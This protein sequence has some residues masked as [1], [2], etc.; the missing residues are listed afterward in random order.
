MRTHQLVAL[1]ALSADI[2]LRIVP[3]LSQTRPGHPQWPASPSVAARAAD[4]TP[5]A[6]PAGDTM[7]RLVTP[8]AT[9]RIVS[10]QPGDQVSISDYAPPGSAVGDGRIL[11]VIQPQA[12]GDGHVT[13]GATGRAVA[14]E[15]VTSPSLPPDTTIERVGHDRAVRVSQAISD[16]VLKATA[17]DRRVPTPSMPNML[18]FS[19]RLGLP[20]G[21]AVVGPGVSTGTTVAGVSYP[22]AGGTVVFLDLPVAADLPAGRVIGFSFTAVDLTLSRGWSAP[23]AT[24]SEVGLVTH[25]DWPAFQ[26]AAFFLAPEHGGAG[27]TIWVPS[28]T[29]FLSRTANTYDGVSYEFGDAVRFVPGSGSTDVVPLGITDA[30]NLT[31][32]GST[33]NP[34]ATSLVVAQS[35]FQQPRRTLQDQALLVTQNN[36]N[37]A[38]DGGGNGCGM[39][40]AEV[41]Q[42]I[43]AAI[44][45]GILWA[46]HSTDDALPGQSVAYAGA[47]LELRNNTG[48]DWM[49]NSTFGNKTGLHIDDLG[50]TPNTVAL[51]AGGNAPTGGGWHR[52]MDCDSITILDYCFDIQDGP[53]SGAG[54]E[55]VIVAGLSMNGHFLGTGLSIY[56]RP[57]KP[58]RALAPTGAVIDASG[59][60]GVRSL[61]TQVITGETGLLAAVEVQDGGATDTPYALAVQPPPGGATATIAATGYAL[62]LLQGAA[63]VNRPVGARAG[64]LYTLPGGTCS[65]QPQVGYDGSAWHV[66][67]AGICAVPPVGTQ[68]I[69]LTATGGSATIRPSFWPMWRLLGI[70]VRDGGAGYDPAI[71]PVIEARTS[72]SSIMM[73]RL[74]PTMTGVAAPIR[75]RTG[76][77]TAMSIG[78]DGTVAVPGGL[79]V[80]GRTSVG[81]LSATGGIRAATIQPLG[82]LILRPAAA[83]YVMRASDCGTTLEPRPSG[84]MTITVPAALPLGCKVEIIQVTAQGIGFAGR[85]GMALRSLKAAS[86]LS[87]LY[88][89][90]TILIDGDA[91]FSLSGDI[92]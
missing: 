62:R 28:G 81:T 66:E 65:V 55:P 87:G 24:G 70:A 43:A 56:A 50:N 21:A 61:S 14:G 23:L 25:D 26:D 1:A 39:V 88:G 19:S 86:R 16:P 2:L 71:P 40:G 49:W 51:M 60:A 89:K 10:G 74:I 3:G 58:D 48:I 63:P 75:L 72:G 41:K 30:A 64:D 31:I 67:T 12:I 59:N 33:R 27:G 9:G 4:T 44:T 76:T 22:E 5:V 18:R 32:G 84:P 17:L 69:P 90:A 6:V 91:S 42:G 52:S 11:T 36:I 7:R 53:L 57:G 68:S 85:S 46:Y 92:Q 38:N 13:V 80:A 45:R 35:I 34:V 83:D 82:S 20:P 47:E 15:L 78:V 79:S 77:M 73:P 29:Y 54:L 37:C 8:G